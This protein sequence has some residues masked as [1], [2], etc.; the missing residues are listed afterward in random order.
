VPVTQMPQAQARFLAARTYWI[1]HTAEDPAGF[2]AAIHRV[3]ASVDRDV[4]A[5]TVRTA[6]DVIS[7]SLGSRRFNLQLIEFVAGAALLVAALGVYA[8]TAFAVAQRRRELAVRA[9]CGASAAR[10]A[11]AI[12]A[13]ELRTIAGGALAGMAGAVAAGPVV[14]AS[15]YGVAPLDTTA[16]GA[17]ATVIAAMALVAVGIPA[18]RVRRLSIARELQAPAGGPW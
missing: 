8:M 16:V 6:T 15:L 11:S 10:L 4:A 17:T 13:G 18:A 5:S 2:A 9:A 7:S 12:V 3:V 14:R 1:V